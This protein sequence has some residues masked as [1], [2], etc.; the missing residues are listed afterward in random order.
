MSEQQEN[1]K[2]KIGIFGGSFDPWG[3]HHSAIVTKALEQLDQVFIVPTT[4]KY[5]RE[6]KRYLFTFDEKVKIIYEFL[7]GING[8]VAI[9]DVERDKDESWR[10]IN[11]VEYFHNK[12]PD[13][14]LYLIIGEDSHDYFDTWFRYDDILRIAKLI[15]VNRSKKERTYKW[16]AI[17]ISIGEGFVECSATKI[18]Q[19]L[20]DE[21]LD[22]YMNDKEWYCV[23]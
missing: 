4:V 3:L 1:T 13:A 5:Y 8:N 9:D 2:K 22:S 23:E 10:T 18:R 20:I 19:R 6:D 16:D 14:E 21:L 11:T 15:V 17:P 12:F 7:T